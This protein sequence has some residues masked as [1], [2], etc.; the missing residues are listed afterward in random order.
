[1]PQ[2]GEENILVVAVPGDA[3]HESVGPCRDLVPPYLASCMAVRNMC[4]SIAADSQQ[5]HSSHLR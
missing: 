1:M 2:I 5:L 3:S 4:L